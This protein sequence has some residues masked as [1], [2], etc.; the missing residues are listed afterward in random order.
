MVRYGLFTKVRHT[1]GGDIGGA[2]G[3]LALVKS[4]LKNKNIHKDMDQNER[5]EDV[6]DEN[7]ASCHNLKSEKMRVRS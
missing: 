2:C 6:E 7:E 3:Q 4:S 1:C 5:N